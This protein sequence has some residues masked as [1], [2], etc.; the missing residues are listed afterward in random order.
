MKEL[1]PLHAALRDLAA[2]FA[3]MKIPHAFIGGVAAA[4]QGRPR[5]TQD[6]DSL[7]LLDD[8]RWDEFLAVGERFGFQPR[9]TD[10]MGFA[11]KEHVLL[12][13]HTAS[14]IPVDVSFAYLPF[15]EK[16]LARAPVVIMGDLSF[17][18]PTPSDL[19][20]M[21]AVAHRGKDAVDIENVLDA[22]PDVDAAEI[23]RTVKEFSDVLEAPEIFADLDAMLRRKG[24]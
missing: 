17:P 12:L 1:S 21:K 2:W 13:K 4:L 18:I 19:I 7:V 11:R 14:N 10:A 16:A 22:H 9:V 5:M 3:S 20:V 6:V 8:S 15:E 24:L 23:R